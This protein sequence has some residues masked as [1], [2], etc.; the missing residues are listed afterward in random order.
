MKV[1][2]ACSLILLLP[3]TIFCQS[4]PEKWLTPCER[5]GFIKTPRYNETMEYCRKLAK[6]SP[7]IKVTSFGKSPEGRDLP[8]VIAS[9]GKEFDPK[10]AAKS[11]KAILLIQNG[12]HAGEIEG[13]DACLMLLRYI[14]ITK[15][16]SSLLDHVILLVIPIYNVDGHERFG[17]YN[18]IN[19]NG[20]EEMG[21]R[22]NAQNLNLNRDYIK[23]DAPETQAW[24]KLFNAWLPDFFVDCHVTD[25]ADYQYIV[26]YGIETQG[27]VAPPVREWIREKYLPFL[28]TVRTNGVPIAPQIY[29]VDDLDP[30]KGLE[31]TDGT[32][33]P[34]FSTVYTTL[35]NRPGLL[36]EM[37]MLKKYKAR[38]EGNY[39]I[40]D[41]TMRLLN[42]EY[43]SVRQAVRSADSLTAATITLPHLFGLQFQSDTIPNSTL[44]YYGVRQKNEPS[45]ISGAPRRVYSIEQIEET[46]PVFDS[47]KATKTIVPPIAYLIP[48][49][50]Q[51]VIERLKLHGLHLQRLRLPSRLEVEE[52]RFSNAKWQQTPFEGRHRVSYSVEKTTGWKLF[53]AGTIVVPLNQRAAKVAINAL[54]PE[55]PDA[56]VSWGFFDAIFEQKE[57]AEDYVMEKLARDMISKNPNL[58]AEFDAKLRSDTAFAN[59]PGARLNF[60]YQRS[61]YWDKQVGLYPV[62][63]LML[64]TG[65]YTEPLK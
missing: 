22:V 53:P 15:T 42:R 65:L 35:Q 8:L 26:T 52:Y 37:H 38:V 33:P 16:K 17:P 58:K 14:A 39:T 41:S 34:R 1:I 18:R 21:W 44:D 2:T 64:N 6:A 12:I 30:L 40:L 51:Q 61:P 19:Q 24:L 27:N 45:E 55:S 59:S 20:P 56:F 5:S 47:I 10:K 43:K 32:A 11:K 3:A 31:G 54:E 9:K 36:I 25:G 29:F 63:R 23:A 13:K 7:W 62:A 46:I 28:S 57:Y 60:F 4:I 50:W 48:S 49:Q